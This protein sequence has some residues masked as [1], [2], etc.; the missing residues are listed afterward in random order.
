[1]ALRPYAPENHVEL[2]R[3]IVDAKVDEILGSPIR[4]DIVEP[5]HDV[6]PS[7][8]GT[9]I[10]VY[11]PARV[12]LA[13]DFLAVALHGRLPIA[14]E[15]ENYKKNRLKVS[16]RTADDHDRALRML[17][18]FC[19]ETGR[20]DALSAVDEDTVTDFIAKLENVERMAARTIKKYVS[21]LNLYFR[22]LKSKRQIKVNPWKDAEVYMPTKKNS[23]L[24]RPS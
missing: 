24:E 4:Y 9:R 6:D 5:G 13:D 14:C 12:K 23:E 16:P 19:I 20:G 21:R 22:Y 7:D 8:V 11:D 17:T 15:D 3:D 1:M 18:E 2:S 10:P